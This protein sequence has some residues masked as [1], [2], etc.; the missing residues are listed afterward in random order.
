MQPDLTRLQQLASERD[1]VNGYLELKRLLDAGELSRSMASE[2]AERW[3]GSRNGYLGLQKRAHN[4]AWAEDMAQI[5]DFPERADAL[6]AENRA[7]GLPSLAEMS[8]NQPA[9]NAQ[10]LLELVGQFAQG[11]TANFADEAAMGGRHAVREHL[12][13][14]QSRHPIAGTMA[15]MGGAALPVA[16]I[17]KAAQAAGRLG[18]PVARALS[19]GLG[20]TR[21]GLSRLLNRVRGNVPRQA[22]IPPLDPLMAYKTARPM[23]VSMA[24][25]AKNIGRGA[26]E[27][28]LYGTVEGVGAGEGGAERLSQGLLGGVLGGAAGGALM[29]G[30]GLYGAARGVLAKARGPSTSTLFG[31]YIRR[32]LPGV[33]MGEEGLIAAQRALADRDA[34]Y[35]VF[36]GEHDAVTNPDVLAAIDEIWNEQPI[37]P[38]RRFLDRRIVEVPSVPKYERPTWHA[39]SRMRGILH[40]EGAGSGP[41]M[42]NDM[43]ERYKAEMGDKLPFVTVNKGGFQTKDI[44][45]KHYIDD[46]KASGRAIID[47]LS[48]SEDPLVRRYADRNLAGRFPVQGQPRQMEQPPLNIIH[49]NMQ[50]MR[51]NPTTR[52]TGVALNR[53]LREKVPGY[54]SLEDQYAA[55][56]RARD[57][58][59][60][61]KKEWDA[62]PAERDAAKLQLDEREF[63]L[64]NEQQLSEI[65]RRLTDNRSD[66]AAGRALAR[67]MDAGPTQQAMVADMI[68]FSFQGGPMSKLFQRELSDAIANEQSM[69]IFA[70]RVIEFLTAIG[71]GTSARWALGRATANIAS[72]TSGAHMHFPTFR[73]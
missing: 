27:G 54:G 32:N 60:R 6:E 56:A 23:R 45:P 61:G 62:T 50:R 33:D 66:A 1:V 30:S 34:A 44:D 10:D 48:E 46:T 22:P 71:A 40:S 28:A 20:R 31:D 25:G 47:W 26:A 29:A 8:P 18:F 58:R 15:Y 63:L 14:F 65:V 2:Y 42:L 3:F 17:G 24:E 13:D 72:Q 41:R 37:N 16:R 19:T 11:A 53:T 73:R 7:Q 5:R 4:M 64:Y 36:M 49:E 39:L 69:G 21:A 38:A 55:A 52:E 43:L 9:W 35:K 67:F 59:V 68:D 12:S 51:D 70:P 57:A